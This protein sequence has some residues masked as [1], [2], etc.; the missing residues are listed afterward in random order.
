MGRS[1]SY[2]DSVRWARCLSEVLKQASQL[3]NESARAAYVEVS[4]RLQVSAAAHSILCGLQHSILQSMSLC[5]K[6]CYVSKTW[7]NIT[8]HLQPWSSCCQMYPC[9]C[10]VLQGKNKRSSTACGLKAAE[11][12]IGGMSAG[13]DVQ[14]QQPPGDPANRQPWGD[15]QGRSVPHLLYGGGCLPPLHPLCQPGPGSTPHQGALQG[16]VLQCQVC[17]TFQ[18]LFIAQL[19]CPC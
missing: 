13:A 10:K 9:L 15:K 8:A 18:Q 1:S 2:E 12:G 7:H 19:D 17:T 3:C 11:T 4:S 5:T 14:E 6:P 16:H